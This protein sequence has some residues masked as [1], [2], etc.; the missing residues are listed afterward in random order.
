[1]SVKSL[2][3][4]LRSVVS[5]RS[6]LCDA[7]WMSCEMMTFRSVDADFCTLMFESSPLLP[8]SRP[9][10]FLSVIFCQPAPPSPRSILCAQGKLSFCC[11]FFCQQSFLKDLFFQRKFC[12]LCGSQDAVSDSF[13]LYGFVFQRDP[14]VP[15]L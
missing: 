12:L 13:S 9:L 8:V 11:F 2:I 3:I 5:I 14:A 15:S 10:S 4:F 6:Y 7:E 1:M